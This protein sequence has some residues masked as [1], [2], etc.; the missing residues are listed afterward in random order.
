MI[1]KLHPYYKTG[2]YGWL[3][4]EVDDNDYIIC[5]ICG[6]ILGMNYWDYAAEN[7]SDDKCPNCKQE[8]DYSEIYKFEDT[9]YYQQLLDIVNDQLHLKNIA[10]QLAC[11]H[12]DDFVGSCKFCPYGK[13]DENG[14]F[15]SCPDVCPDGI[16][17]LSD[18]FESQAKE[19]IE[20]ETTK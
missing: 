6:E 20:N 19:M 17:V 2:I 3:G 1:K 13:E 14:K 9:C 12:L 18:Y 16:S 5:P 7:N 8:L 10:L 11:Q 4:E 15:Q